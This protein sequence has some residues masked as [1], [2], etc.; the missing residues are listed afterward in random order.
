MGD[1]VGDFPLEQN[2]LEADNWS[3]SNCPGS[4]ASSVLIR[5]SV[6]YF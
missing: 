1:V 6:A 3:P 2:M 4:P 5:Q